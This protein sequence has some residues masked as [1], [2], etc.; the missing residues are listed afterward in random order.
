MLI[1]I[2]LKQTL[3]QKSCLHCQNP[4][5]RTNSLCSSVL[6]WASF[7]FC[8]LIN[9][10]VLEW[11]LPIICKKHYKK[12]STL[13]SRNHPTLLL[14]NKRRST[15]ATG[16]FLSKKIFVKISRQSQKNTCVEVSLNKV[17]LHRK[18]CT[19]IKKRSPTQMFSCEYWEIS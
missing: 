11:F 7:G 3:R 1:C 16:G 2:S 4:N 18:A 5:F 15:D 12:S 9:K 19:F 8:S 17:G 13:F 6:L 14:F 10:S